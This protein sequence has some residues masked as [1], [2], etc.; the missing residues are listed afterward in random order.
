MSREKGGF[1]IEFNIN[2]L[3]NGLAIDLLS[4]VDITSGSVISDTLIRLG[5]SD[6]DGGY[7]VA[8]LNEELNPWEIFYFTGITP[9]HV[10]I[11]VHDEF[12]SFYI[13]ESWVH[14]IYFPNINYPDYDDLE[15]FLRSSGSN[16]DV[17]DIVVT[18]LCDWREAIYV[19]LDTVAANAIS[20][21]IQQR[22]VEIRPTYLGEVRF[23]Y[24]NDDKRDVV[25]LSSNLLKVATKKIDSSNVVS[26]AIVYG[27]IVEVLTRWWTAAKHGFITKIIRVPELD[28]G[29]RRAAKEIMKQLEQQS[30]EY[31]LVVRS[32]LRIEI[33]DIITCEYV[34][35][36]TKKTIVVNCIVEDINVS[37]QNAIFE[38]TIVGRG[39]DA[40]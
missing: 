5:R 17:E 37:I 10:R 4:N 13:N 21:I 28:T 18:D 15:I 12:A 20:S 39:Y 22:P 16:I 32:D 19:D 31:T 38:M 7:Y 8:A 29:A 30:E 6:E 33:G 2:G 1:D 24:S 36:G 35:S 11:C 34:I 25:T 26:D 14:T 27:S 9:Y 40:A 23:Q 3:G